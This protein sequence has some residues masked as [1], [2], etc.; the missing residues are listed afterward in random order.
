MLAV[1]CGG[2]GGE[3]TVSKATFVATAEAICHKTNQEELAAYTGSAGS[4]RK[5]LG[6]RA[7]EA[8]GEKQ[9]QRTVVKA[10]L[11]TIPKEIEELEGLPLP[12]GSEEDA[13][14]FIQGV[15]EAA[16]Q[17]KPGAGFKELETAFA[18]A[19]AAAQKFGFEKCAEAP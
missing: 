2:G 15:K 12:E 1:A 13:E 4:A 18:P 17:T 11:L 16:S 9:Q 7:S 6:A 3:P 19:A 5:A 14:A 10:W 8:F